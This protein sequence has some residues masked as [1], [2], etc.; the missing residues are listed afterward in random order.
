VTVASPFVPHDE[1]TAPN[2]H[3]FDPLPAERAAAWENF[4][5]WP[6]QTYFPNLVGIVKEEIRVDYCRLRL[7][8]RPELNQPAGVVHGGAL[9]T[10]IDTVVVPA[11]GAVYDTR[12]VMLTIS[13]NIN[14]LSAVRD[15]D[16]VAEGWV[17]R[18][19]R[20]TVFC[21]AEVRAADGELAAVASLVYAVRIPIS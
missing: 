9:A 17:E 15:Q 4:A 10:L 1:L 13:M 18:R 16:A 3:R 11:V 12:P 19:G 5:T 21:R 7:Q 8:F 2:A 20:S 6:G 14:Y